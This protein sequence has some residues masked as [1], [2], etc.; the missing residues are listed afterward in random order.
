MENRDQ[1]ILSEITSLIESIKSQLAVLEDKLA[2]ITMSPVL[3]EE[4]LAPIDL[5][6]IEDEP[7]ADVVEMPVEEPVEIE[8]P[9]ET[10]E[11][12]EIEEPVEDDDLPFYDEEPVDKSV[13]VDVQVE[14]EEIEAEEVEDIEDEVAEEKEAETVLSPVEEEIPVLPVKEEPKNE[15]RRAVIDAMASKQAWR[16]DMPGL[17]VKDIRS[18]IS[19]NDRL[20]FIN[21]LFH[22]D[23]MAFQESLTKINALQS[24]DEV[25][26]MLAES[27]P[28]WDFESEVVYRF[29]MAVRRKIR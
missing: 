22:E 11:L 3:E 7:V 19:L 26:S 24:L 12:V 25:V 28:E 10:E 5:E 9:V 4:D 14:T 18:A 1:Q 29:M 20:I 17:A 21:Y 16:T 13:E 27:H 8:E 23:P 6:I 2:Q 15:S